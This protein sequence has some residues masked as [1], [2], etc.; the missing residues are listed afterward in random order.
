MSKSTDSSPPGRATPR[1]EL[2]VDEARATRR[3]FHGDPSAIASRSEKTATRALRFEG[4]ENVVVP[5]P[6]V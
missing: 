3:S 5:E 4:K 2:D 1:L 6:A